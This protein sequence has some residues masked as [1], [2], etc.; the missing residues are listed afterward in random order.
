MRVNKFNIKSTLFEI[1]LKEF[2]TLYCDSINSDEIEK[3]WN[4]NLNENIHF[5]C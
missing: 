2:K 4:R 1:D 5:D 3:S